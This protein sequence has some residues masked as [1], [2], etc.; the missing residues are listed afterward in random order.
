M[1]HDS[2]GMQVMNLFLFP[3]Q[4]WSLALECRNFRDG[5]SPWAQWLVQGSCIA[6]FKEVARLCVCVCQFNLMVF[7]SIWQFDVALLFQ[8]T[9][10]KCN[11]D[12]W[13]MFLLLVGPMRLCLC[14][15]YATTGG[16]NSRTQSKF[17]NRHIYIYIHINNIFNIQLWSHK[18][19]HL[20]SC[21]SLLLVNT[22]WQGH[23]FSILF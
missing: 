20:S 10:V 12:S 9:C 11:S 1:F 17:N 3:Y 4:A 2:Q 14:A 8:K 7:E 16:I 19:S 5:L 6:R 13:Y 22:R 23:E 21:I 15:S 18:W